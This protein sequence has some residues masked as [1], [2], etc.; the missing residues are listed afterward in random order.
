M[1]LYPH[2]IHAAPFGAVLAR[3]GVQRL[4]MDVP[5]F[6][7]PADLAGGEVPIAVHAPF[8]IATKGRSCRIAGLG[9]AE[10]AKF[11]AGG[12]C[13]QECLHYS[14]TLDRPGAAQD[15]PTRLRGT[16]ML[17]AHAPGMAAA[18]L[19][20]ARRGTIDRIILSGDWH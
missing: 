15:L 13:T 18:V 19:E 16:A 17:Y 12:R 7:Q 8:G 5:P 11:V 2:G 9:R 6:A 4:E 10:A 14:T 3:L 20:A 1:R